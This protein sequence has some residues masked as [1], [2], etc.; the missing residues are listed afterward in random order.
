M[1][2]DRVVCLHLLIR[3]NRMKYV[4]KWNNECSSVILF[5]FIRHVPVCALYTH[6]DSHLLVRAFL[7]NFRLQ[8]IV[9]AVQMQFI[10]CE[11]T[12]L[13][14]QANE[15]EI[16]FPKLNC[17]ICLLCSSS[18]LA[19]IARKRPHEGYNTS[20]DSEEEL[21]RRLQMQQSSSL[22]S[23]QLSKYGAGPLNENLNSLKHITVATHRERFNDPLGVAERGKVGVPSSSECS[24]NSS[25]DASVESN[26]GILH[27]ERKGNFNFHFEFDRILIL[28]SVPRR[29]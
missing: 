7:K 25:A 23:G 18:L 16:Y 13:C 11:R 26:M 22:H 20:S 3:S 17:F 8:W 24:S 9:V 28:F 1:R 19:L 12:C 5:H 21:L 27:G 6:G 10:T 29:G 4:N 2:S 15:I 14:A